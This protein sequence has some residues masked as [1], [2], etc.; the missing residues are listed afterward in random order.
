MQGLEA[1]SLACPV[2]AFSDD[3]IEHQGT[4]FADPVLNAEFAVPVP[5]PGPP[6][7]I[8]PVDEKSDDYLFDEL[9]G[10]ALVAELCRRRSEVRV[11]ALADHA[12]PHLAIYA[13]AARHGLIRKVDA[14]ARRA[15][16]ANDT[17]FEYL[18][19]TGTRNYSLVRFLRSPEDAAP[20]GRTQA[21]QAILRSLG[22]R[23][24][25]ETGAAGS[26]LGFDDLMDDFLQTGEV[27]DGREDE[28]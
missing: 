5:A 8:I 17:I 28:E 19:R 27:T 18:G 26:Q 12:I 2:L 7:R 4:A 23:S 9:V 21:Y 16:E 24:G 25:T 14:A 20:Q 22:R 11:P 13:A 15:A 3:S 6:P 10:A 1:A